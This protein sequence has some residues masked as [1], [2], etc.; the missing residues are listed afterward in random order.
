MGQQQ[1]RFRAYSVRISSFPER[2][3]PEAGDSR[4]KMG[5]AFAKPATAWPRLAKS[6]IMTPEPACKLLIHGLLAGKTTAQVVI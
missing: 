2:V 5:E 4:L 6:L 3:G 1:D